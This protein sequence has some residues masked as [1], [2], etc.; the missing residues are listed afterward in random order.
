MENQVKINIDGVNLE[1]ILTIPERSSGLILFAHGSGSSRFSPR[2]NFV[3]RRLQENDMG[4]LL[5]DLLLLKEDLDY[6]T[7][8]NIDLLSSRLTEISRWLMGKKETKDLNLGLFG[9]STGAAAALITSVEVGL[10]IKAVVSRGG[11]PDMANEALTR[12]QAPTLLIV[13]GNDNKVIELNRAA[14]K[15]LGSQ[16]KKMEIVEGAT[17]L[18]EEQGAL[19]KVADLAIVWFEKYLNSSI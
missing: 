8:F 14:Y 6:N 1:G 13:G 5:I 17:H 11:R 4:T 2:N 10:K 9:A 16:V 19:D 12:V 18:F 7:R 15:I 3:A